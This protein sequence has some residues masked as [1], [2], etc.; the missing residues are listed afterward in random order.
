MLFC[1]LFL[2]L[3]HQFHLFI[4]CFCFKKFLI[5]ISLFRV[6]KIHN[7]LSMTKV[8]SFWV[9]RLLN[10]KKK[11]QRVR[12]AHDILNELERLGPDAMRKYTLLKMKHG[13]NSMSLFLNKKKKVYSS[14]SASFY[15]TSSINKGQG[16]SLD[17]PNSKQKVFCQS[18][19]IWADNWLIG[20]HKLP[21]LT[22]EHWR[23]LRRLCDISLQ[24]FKTNS[25]LHFT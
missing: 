4:F 18:N 7:D 17:L 2:F 13:K 19:F 10:D 9:P 16:S 25:I 23:K 21:Q 20:V 3:F 5:F 1:F 11:Q 12:S 24:C 22:A 8:C 15:S 14:C 6:F